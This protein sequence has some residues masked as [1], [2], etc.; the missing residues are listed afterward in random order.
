MWTGIPPPP[1]N[2]GGIWGK[3]LLDATG[4][5]KLRDPF[6]KTVLPLPKTD[7]ADLTVYVDAE[8]GTAKSGQRNFDR[9]HQQTRLSDHF[10]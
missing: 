6:V 10:S 2:N 8:N 9:D 4:P 3:V 1:D 7:S 5:V